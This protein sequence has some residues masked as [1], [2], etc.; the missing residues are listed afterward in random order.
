VEH[1]L[2]ET[3]TKHDSHSNFLSR[4]D[5]QIVNETDRKN[6]GKNIGRNVGNGICDVE[7]IDINIAAAIGDAEIPSLLDRGALENTHKDIRRC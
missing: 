2:Q 5:M 3:E 7:C 6:I 4:G 1:N